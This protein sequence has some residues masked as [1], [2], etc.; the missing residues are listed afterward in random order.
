VKIALIAHHK[1][2]VHP[3]KLDIVYIKINVMKDVVTYQEITIIV[4]IVQ[5]VMNIVKNVLAHY[6]PN[7]SNV[8]VHIMAYKYMKI[9]LLL[10]VLL[11]FVMI[12]LQHHKKYVM[13]V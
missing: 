8:K 2:F 1:T 6:Q 4:L 9:L 13:M 7:V 11:L 10:H 5:Y 3:A 12:I